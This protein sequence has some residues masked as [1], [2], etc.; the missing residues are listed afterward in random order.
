M[1]NLVFQHVIDILLAAMIALILDTTLAIIA[2]ETLGLDVVT[3]VHCVILVSAALETSS[4]TIFN[5]IKG[6]SPLEIEEG[7]EYD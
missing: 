7:D 6:T 1:A 2:D 3:L 5:A 4:D